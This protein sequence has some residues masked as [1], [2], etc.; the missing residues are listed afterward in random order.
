ML[1]TRVVVKG[2]APTIGVVDEAP[3]GLEVVASGLMVVKGGAPSVGVV[4]HP[5]AYGLLVKRGARKVG[6]V[7]QPL[8]WVL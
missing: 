5:L 3:V 7:D 1:E 6:V 4:Q 8:G 2:G